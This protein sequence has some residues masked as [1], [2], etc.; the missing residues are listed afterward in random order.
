[1][2]SP[3]AQTQKGRGTI[4]QHGANPAHP[5][6]PTHTHTHAVKG[7][8]GTCPHHRAQSWGRLLLSQLAS[9]APGGL[10]STS[11]KI[12]A[13]HVIL[14]CASV[15]SSPEVVGGPVTRLKGGSVSILGRVGSQ[16]CGCTRGAGPAGIS[17][18]SSRGY[19]LFH[20]KHFLFRSRVGA[21]Q[22]SLRSSLPQLRRRSTQPQPVNTSGPRR[23]VG[24]RREPSHTSRGRGRVQKLLPQHPAFQRLPSPKWTPSLRGRD[25]TQGG[26]MGRSGGGMVE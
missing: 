13:F 10:W 8:P 20:L 18:H 4:H 7:C 12:N 15:Q 11:A 25:T 17:S 26:R 5:R 6:P 19:P 9:P 24:Q 1:M 2:R 16:G 3:G 23:P 14:S 22:T 21:D